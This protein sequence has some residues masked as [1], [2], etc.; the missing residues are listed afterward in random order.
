MLP[1][2]PRHRALVALLA[3]ACGLAGCLS[4][5][6]R[7]L[8]SVEQSTTTAELRPEL[9]FA[10][11]THGEGALF[12]RGRR[13]RPLHVEGMGRTERDGAFRLDQM[14]TYDDGASETRSFRVQ[15]T[16][17]THYTATL[18]DAK[19]PV[20][21]ETIGSRFHLRY[22]LRQPAVYME[23]DLYLHGDGRSVTNEATVTVLGIPVARLA[24]TIV[25][26]D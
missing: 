20:A 9:F 15:R 13:P 6:P 2:H 4:G 7:R 14:V 8:E 10:G 25:R 11:R 22:L 24:E 5:F 1:H 16:D 19:G 17:A 12:V 3:G 21:A 23:Q 26:P 18:S